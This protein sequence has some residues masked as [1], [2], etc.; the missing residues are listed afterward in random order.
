MLA[1]L[2]FKKFSYMKLA[3]SLASSMVIPQ[4]ALSSSEWAIMIL[5]QMRSKASFLSS[6][7]RRVGTSGLPEAFSCCRLR[8]AKNNPVI[9]QGM[10]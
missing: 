3:S 10:G 2:I 8:R 9:K 6:P 4:V 5:P 7:R 1:L